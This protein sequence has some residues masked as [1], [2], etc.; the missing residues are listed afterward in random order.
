MSQILSLLKKL[1]A[2]C[3]SDVDSDVDV[4]HNNGTLLCIINSCLA[5]ERHCFDIQS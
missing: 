1:N 3:K 2:A 5:L 4:Q